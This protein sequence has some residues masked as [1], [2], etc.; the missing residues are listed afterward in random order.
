TSHV[1]VLS[2]E[3]S[4]NGDSTAI[5]ASIKGLFSELDPSKVSTEIIHQRYPNTDSYTI[6]ASFEPKSDQAIAYVDEFAQS[7]REFSVG[8]VKI[9][10]RPATSV[11]EFL[12]LE[13]FGPNETGTKEVSWGTFVRYRQFS[14]VSDYFTSVV[15]LGTAL[16]QGSKNEILTNILPILN[17]V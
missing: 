9:S 7:H 6:E 4:I 14:S 3:G 8:N 2:Y 5:E 10:L 1:Y 12:S 15:Q 13:C 17:P 16:S 11:A